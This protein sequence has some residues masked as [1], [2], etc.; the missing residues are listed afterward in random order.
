MEKFQ[1]IKKVEVNCLMVK[2]PLKEKIRNYRFFFLRLHNDSAIF[3]FSC[4]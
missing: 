1:E 4:Q 3:T 2:F